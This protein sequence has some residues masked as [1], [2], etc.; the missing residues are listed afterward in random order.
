MVAGF[1]IELLLL[2]LH[3]L[4]TVLVGSG[5]CPHFVHSRELS[6]EALKVR[7]MIEGLISIYGYCDIRGIHWV[8][9]IKKYWYVEMSA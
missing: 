5:S 6:I 9:G 3:M 7:L 2:A 8:C 4:L 1:D